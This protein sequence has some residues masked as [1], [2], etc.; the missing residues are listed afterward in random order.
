MFPYA[1]RVTPADRQAIIAYIRALQ[2][3]RNAPID[4]LE[5]EDVARLHAVAVSR[6]QP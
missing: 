3:S 5:P 6:S 4:R 1:D 2:F